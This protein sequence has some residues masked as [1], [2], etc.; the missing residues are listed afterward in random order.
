[1][2]VLVAHTNFDLIEVSLATEVQIQSL[3]RNREVIR[4]A[5]LCP[6]LYGYWLQ[7]M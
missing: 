4:V 3:A 6:G 2:T 1:M 7:F 5:E